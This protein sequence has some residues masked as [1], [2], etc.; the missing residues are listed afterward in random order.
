MRS[1]VVSWPAAIALGLCAAAPIAET[2]AQAL[3]PPKGEGTVSFVVSNFLVVDH[4]GGAGQ[5]DKVGEVRSNSLLTDVTYGV[6]DRLAVS[7]SVPWVVSKY[8][9]SRPHPNTVVDNGEYHDT[10]QDL[11]FAAR[12]N[13]TRGPAWITPF[14]S[15]GLPTHEYASYGHAAAG[16]RLRE[17]QFGVS[18]A[19]V[20]DPWLPRAFVQGRYAFGLAEEVLGYRPNRSYIDFEGGYFVTPSFRAF[21]ILTSHLAH[22]GVTFPPEGPRGIGPVLF[23]YHD[24]IAAE[25]MLNVGGGLG[26]SASDSLDVFG[27]LVTTTWG[28]NGHALNYG[29]SLGVTWTFRKSAEARA[30]M[31]ARPEGSLVKCACQKQARLD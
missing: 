3:T 1:R 7:I 11:S 2:R 20:L 5:R 14:V 13:L 18:V 28:R 30:A 22:G 29:L 16:R 17:L 12:Y 23:P 10:F 4:L 27:S 8:T 15:T 9:G 24:R 25:E 31:A 6:T 26:F 21:G 19:K